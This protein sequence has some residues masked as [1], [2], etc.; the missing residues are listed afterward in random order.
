MLC[1]QE[2]GKVSATGVSDMLESSKT[3]HTV[4]N[5]S[6]FIFQSAISNSTHLDQEN[7]QIFWSLDG[8]DA[9]NM[10]SQRVL[11]RHSEAQHIVAVS[12]DIDL[13]ITRLQHS[14]LL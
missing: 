5:S 11:R 7:D 4:L 9:R 6:V 2:Q 10:G 1:T 3:C 8:K 12:C 13:Q 14:C